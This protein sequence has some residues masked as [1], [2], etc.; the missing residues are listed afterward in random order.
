MPL[1]VNYKMR[2]KSCTSNSATVAVTIAA[3]CYSISHRWQVSVALNYFALTVVNYICSLQFL[4]FSDWTGLSCSQKKRKENEELHV[5]KI[6]Y[7]VLLLFGLILCVCVSICLISI[8]IKRK[9]TSLCFT[10]EI[11]S[12]TE[13]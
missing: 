4:S 5:I 10:R 7:V 11:N 13:R 12:Q 6:V 1:R 8:V 9:R 3:C 2:K